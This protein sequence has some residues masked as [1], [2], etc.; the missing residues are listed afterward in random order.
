MRDAIWWKDACL[1]YFQQFSKK[2]FPYSIEQPIHEL[3]ELQKAIL[4]ISN[5]ECPDS[6]LLNAIR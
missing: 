1:L 5:F 6:K 4:P 2:S 3:N